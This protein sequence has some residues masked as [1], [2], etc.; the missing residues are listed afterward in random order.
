[1]VLL[2]S[3]QAAAALKIQRNK[4]DRSDAHG[5][6]QL[7]RTGWFRPVHVKSV[8]SHRLLLLLTHRRTL[9]R[10]L[11]DIENEVRQSLKVFGLMLGP[12]IQRRSFETRARARGASPAH[13]RRDGVHAARLVDAVERIQAAA[14]AARPVRQS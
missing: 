12:R 10:K 3:R 9:K 11:P 8:E 14:H 6:A 13:R 4:T 2:E 1:M 7:V 5:L